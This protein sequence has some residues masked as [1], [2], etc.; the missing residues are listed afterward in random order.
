M[1]G[2]A[3]GMAW[4]TVCE[5]RAGVAPVDPFPHSPVHS[6]EAAKAEGRHDDARVVGAQPFID[7][8]ARKKIE[9]VKAGEVEDRKERARRLWK[10]HVNRRG[11]RGENLGCVGVSDL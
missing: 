1:I 9:R 10:R 2:S 7:A 8:L 4:G 11:D 5:R 3:C 6:A